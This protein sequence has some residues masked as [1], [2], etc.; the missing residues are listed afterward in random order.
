MS[1]RTI[2]ELPEVTKIKA[3]DVIPI[4]QDNVTSKILASKF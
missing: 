2:T 4:V 3:T 1:N